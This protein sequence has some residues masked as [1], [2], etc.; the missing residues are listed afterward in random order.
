MK[1]FRRR[2]SNEQFDVESGGGLKQRSENGRV[3]TSP[4]AL[5]RLDHD[6]T[7]AK[8]CHDSTQESASEVREV[9]CCILN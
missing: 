8:L 1:S 5:S 7:R 2:E 4:E 6:S 9:V 3:S